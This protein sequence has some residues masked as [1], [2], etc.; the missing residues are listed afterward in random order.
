MVS[1]ER[2]YLT[3]IEGYRDVKSISCAFSY[4]PGSG[5]DFMPPCWELRFFDV[6]EIQSN[7]SWRRSL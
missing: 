6:N 1:G 4:T 3:M 5:W 7:H 2:L